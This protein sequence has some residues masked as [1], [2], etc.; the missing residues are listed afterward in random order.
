MATWFFEN[1]DAVLMPP[2]VI[3]FSCFLLRG[4]M[5]PGW[6]W[7]DAAYPSS[8][9]AWAGGYVLAFSPFPALLVNVL[10]FAPQTFILLAMA[11]IAIVRL[12]KT[13]NYRTPSLW[14]VV[15]VG[16]LG[17]GATHFLMFAVASS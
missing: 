14:W 1:I 10:F 4:V 5:P 15:V 3:A 2:L 17:H 11:M 8:A 7:R 13:P 6:R 9:L 16:L 12:L